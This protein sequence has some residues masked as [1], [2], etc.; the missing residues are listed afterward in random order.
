MR[1]TCRKRGEWARLIR[2]YK[3]QHYR[4]TLEQDHG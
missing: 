2:T 1:V 3:F 4:L